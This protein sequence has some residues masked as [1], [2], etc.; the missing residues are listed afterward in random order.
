MYVY[1][2][3]E[4]IMLSVLPI[5]PCPKFMP[6]ILNLFLSHHLAIIYSYIP[7][8]LFFK[9]LVPQPTISYIVADKFV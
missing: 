1:D 8:I 2:K 7:C 6:I 3:P 4:A 9:I 5:I